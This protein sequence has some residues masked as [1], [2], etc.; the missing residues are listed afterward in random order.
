[1]ST[2]EIILSKDADVRE[3]AIRIGQDIGGVANLETDDKTSVVAAINE[4][5]TAVNSI[6]ISIGEEFAK[7]SDLTPLATK[8]ELTQA[9]TDLI[10]GADA[11]S[12]TLK[13]LADKIT[14]LAQTDN[15]LVS[16]T[17]PQTFSEVGKKQ[18]RDNIG[19][20][21]E[22]EVTQAFTDLGNN[23]GGDY[24]SAYLQASQ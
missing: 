7:K 24:V 4:T 6:E 22:A 21:S 2:N 11:D 5:Y 12:D 13:E 20:I 14:A 23:A 16:A 18:A 10:N 8:V 19:A 17:D 15:G 3:L 9:I 1:M